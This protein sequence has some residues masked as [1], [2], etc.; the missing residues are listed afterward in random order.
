MP[1]VVAKLRGK[2]VFARATEALALAA[3]GGRV[4][5]RYSKNDPR[6]Y[7]AAAANLE[8]DW[9][10]A[11][12][13][14]DACLP[15]EVVA[16]NAVSA[17]S[18][19]TATAAPA[20]SLAGAYVAYTDGACSG[21]PGP[22]GLGVIVVAPDGTSAEGFEFLGTA[23]NNIAELTAILRA[24][25]ALPPAVA[26]AVIHTDSQY[27]IGVLSKGWKAK[28]NQEL[29]AKMKATLKTQPHVR[30]VY[31]KGHAGIPLN[32]RADE[33]ARHA[34]TSRQTVLAKLPA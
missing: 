10:Q 12:L 5:I 1:W 9:A 26:H 4:E 3:E 15:G 14:D 29:I 21:N 28:A 27:A 17:K 7:R 8:V 24:V 32:E 23:T 16:S 19:A 6:A 13:P 30:F 31:V 11:L 22:A 18:G 2:N 25:E 20:M 33:L 34:V